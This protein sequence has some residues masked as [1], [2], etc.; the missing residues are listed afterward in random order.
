LP[1]MLLPTLNNCPSNYPALINSLPW[2]DPRREALAVQ[3]WPWQ[4]Y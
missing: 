4:S 3:P 1:G 2:W